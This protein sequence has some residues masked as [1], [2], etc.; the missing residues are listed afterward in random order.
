MADDRLVA[1]HQP[2]FFPWL[3]YFNKAIRADIFVVLDDVQF[4]R[5][6]AGTWSNRVRVL[7]NGAPVWMTMP[8]LREHRSERLQR[9]D[10][11]LIDESQPWRE[12]CVRTLQMHYRRATHFDEVFPWIAALLRNQ[13]ESLVEYNLHAA[14]AIASRLG[15]G[16]EHWVRSSSLS[17]VSTGTQR[18]VDLV[19]AVG[20]TV[21]LSGDGAGGYQD[22][23]AFARA[24][25]GLVLQRFVHPEYDQRTGQPFV[26]G[27]SCIDALMHC[28]FEKTTELLRVGVTHA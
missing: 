7:V 20:G 8:I 23:D 26:A 13:T 22:D 25:V 27:L 14:R 17:V 16:V 1:I 11:I 5:T 6:G 19:R 18:L 24:S 2:N 3:G 4:A 15:C 9:Y 12:K 10:Q 28:G 21:Y